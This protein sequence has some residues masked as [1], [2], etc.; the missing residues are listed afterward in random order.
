M[1]QKKSK[2]IY[3]GSD[4]MLYW[5]SGSPACFRAMI[6]LEEKKLTGFV[7]KH[8]NFLEN[9]HKSEE[10]LRLNSRGQVGRA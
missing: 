9:E 1:G 3:V 2:N 7:Q 8:L 4:M 6:A 10:V 5:I